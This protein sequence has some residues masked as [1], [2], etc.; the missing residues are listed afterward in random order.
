[1][2]HGETGAVLCSVCQNTAEL[3]LIK[4]PPKAVKSRLFLPPVLPHQPPETLPEREYEGHFFDGELKK[5]E[6]RGKAA[7]GAAVDR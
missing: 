5:R 3:H 7:G 6:N 4:S 1:L 2:V